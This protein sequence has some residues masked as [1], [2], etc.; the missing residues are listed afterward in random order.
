MKKL[1]LAT[2]IGIALLFTIG[3]A[4]TYT[5]TME[6]TYTLDLFSFIPWMS[7]GSARIIAMGGAGTALANDASSVE[8]NPA[9][10]AYVK[11]FNLSV[12]ALGEVNKEVTGYDESG[13]P[14]YE[15]KFNFVPLYAAVAISNLGAAYK[16]PF[17]PPIT[18][19]RFDG[20][21]W[22]SRAPDGWEMKFDFYSDVTDTSKLNTISA[23]LGQKL[24]PIA[25]GANL[26]YIS[27]EVS[28]KVDGIYFRSD[29]F[30]GVSEDFNSPPPGSDS[31]F[32]SYD[33]AKIDGYTLDVGAILELAL[34]KIGAVY[35][36]AYSSVN[37]TR[38]YMWH[39]DFVWGNWDAWWTYDPAPETYSNIKLPSFF[40]V[41]AGLDLGAIKVALDLENFDV[42]NNFS[43]ENWN[44]PENW[45]YGT[46]HAGVEFWV[47]PILA[48][49]AGAYGNIRL[50]ELDPTKSAELAVR[51]LTYSVG[52]GVNLLGL[53]VDVAVLGEQI[54]NIS[55]DL[56]HL[57]F[58]ASGSAK[59]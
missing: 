4:Q 44:K 59:F 42:T 57:K 14:K 48:L 16:K 33:W 18:V 6:E 22:T 10:L 36:N 8:Y 58:I 47:L 2:I 1:L 27:G 31:Q 19:Q 5:R 39:D 56:S 12:L 51:G 30:H 25:L 3:F 45:R 35:K 20:G 26:T 43:E 23:G 37:Y 21:Y 54:Q 9:G 13:N 34:I 24:G 46:L 49:R 32:H 17:I 11:N 50:E 38:D 41:G 15:Y 7:G 55:P 29:S 40:N 53:S 28:R 52:A